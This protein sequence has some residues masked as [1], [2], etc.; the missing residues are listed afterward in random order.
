MS[1]AGASNESEAA[2]AAHIPVM[3]TEAL[4][5]LGLK[6]GGIYIDGTFGAG[7]YS[8]A[9]LESF[10]DVRLFAFDQDPAAR[11]AGEALEDAFKPRFQLI[12]DRFSTMAEHDLPAVDGIVLD[13]GVSSMQI[14]QAI[15]GFSF[16]HDGPLDM[17]MGQ[18]GSTAADIINSA[19]EEQIAD[20]LYHFGEERLSRVIARAVVAERLKGPI[21]T[22]RQLAEL[23]AR[24]IRTKP[25]DI[26]PATRSFQALRIA[27]NDELGELARALHAAERLLKPDGMLVI[28]SFHSL[29]DRIVK[30]FFA[31]RSGKGGASRYQPVQKAVATFAIEGKWPVAPGADEVRANPRARSAK[32]RAARRI[33]GPALP[34]DPSIMALAQLP[35]RNSRPPARS[36]KTSSKPRSTRERV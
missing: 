32:L 31:A 14:D 20:I 35:E 25:G 1:R 9:I 12:S 13:I 8:R 22:T 26:H 3:L 18:D 33:A 2:D 28:V 24:V 29:E 21:S 11:A 5:A 23:I 15:R 27:V 19:S 6:P 36:N 16:R 10:P 34:E 4:G 30:Q 7:G 17:R